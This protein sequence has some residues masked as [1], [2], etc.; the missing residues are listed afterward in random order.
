[1][2]TQIKSGKCVHTE[3]CCKTHGCK[4]GDPKCPVSTGDKKQS[5][6]CEDCIEEAE[7]CCNIPQKEVE[8]SLSAIM[9]ALA[10]NPSC[11]QEELFQCCANAFEITE[12]TL[13][14][15]KKM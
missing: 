2:N 13:L 15:L 12:A 5:F 8:E 14:K 4:Y 7:G 10:A 3:H 11:S 1:M 6:A 9:G